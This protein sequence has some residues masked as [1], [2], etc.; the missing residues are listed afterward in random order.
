[1][2][3][4]HFEETVL[5]NGIRIITEEMPHA[6]SVA[7]GIWVRS[8]PRY[9]PATQDGISHFVEHMLFKGTHTRTARQINESLYPVGGHLN[10]FT[11]REFTCYTALVL[12]ED[13]PLAIEVISDM[14]TGSLFA[15]EELEREKNVILEEIRAIEDTPEDLVHDIFA[16]TIWP[17]HALG[18]PVIGKID[19]V[20]SL[21]QEMILKYVR[22]HYTPDSILVAAAGNLDHQVVVDCLQQWL[23]KMEG[24]RVEIPDESP[25]AHA[26]ATI[27]YR[28]T[29][30]AHLCLGMPSFRQQDDDNYP[31]LILDTVLGGGPHSRLFDEIRETRGLA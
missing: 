14:L 23:G 19:T 9:E 10:A 16:S 27:I 5:P 24:R 29:E 11:D 28:K 15:A 21:T 25:Q 18:R 22:T 30:Q 4:E 8:G 12:S 13:V 6:N 17:D 2:L 31:M 1:M 3:T 20:S 26:E 7:L